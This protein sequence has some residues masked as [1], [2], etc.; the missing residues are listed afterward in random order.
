M[1]SNPLLVEH[2]GPVLRVLRQR[3]LDAVFVSTP[4][5]T[6]FVQRREHKLALHERCVA[7]ARARDL[8]CVARIDPRADLALTA[9]GSNELHLYTG[10]KLK[11]RYG[12]TLHRAAL[13]H[14]FA[15]SYGFD[16]LLAHG[17]FE[18]DLFAR[19]IP[20]D[21]IRLIGMPRHAA[22]LAQP[23]SKA[24]ARAQ[25]ALGS[26]RS[27]ITYLPT[28]STQSSL[29]SFLPEL[30]SL[31]RTQRLLVKPHALSLASAQERALLGELERAGAHISEQASAF[32]PLAAAAD[33]LLADATS[34]AATEAALLA[35]ETPLV[36]LSLREPTELFREIERLGP[37]VRVPST[38]PS[39]ITRE[40]QADPYRAR[41]AELCA[42]LFCTRHAPELAADAIMALAQLPKISGKPG[43]IERRWPRVARVA[44]G[45]AIALA[46]RWAPIP[47][48]D[49][50]ARDSL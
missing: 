4:A 32:A 34:G 17:D 6:H 1:L 10:F 18:R 45:R 7:A 22:Y 40:L 15:M 35:P 28:W 20:R 3:G 13:H 19:W 29:Q 23:L 11:L 2:F 14:N 39:A 48:R 41:R 36:L 47:P 31:A 33:L 25:L 21:R 42:R 49:L 44:R 16:G 30:C 37:I 46:A 43:F 38:L 50:G 26:D 27:V 5:A 9:L 8:P 24:E 12:V